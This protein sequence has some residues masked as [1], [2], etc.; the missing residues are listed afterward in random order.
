M[1]ETGENSLMFYPAQSENGGADCSYLLW[2]PCGIR[3][4]EGWVELWAE[5][6]L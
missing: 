6:V 2:L 5:L 4:N 3:K 1:G